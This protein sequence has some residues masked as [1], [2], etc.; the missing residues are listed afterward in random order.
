MAEKGPQNRRELEGA[1]V[2]K[3]WSDD[4]YRGY[5]R[6]DPKAAL[7]TE[8]QEIYPDVKLPEGMEVVLLEESP[9][10]VYVVI[11][12]PPEQLEIARFSDRNLIDMS[13]NGQAFVNLN[14]NVNLNVNVNVNVNV[15]AAVNVGTAADQ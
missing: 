11:P 6:K 14:L 10:K 13:E 7:E 5:F 3:F 15:N 8:L 9:E 1:I 2:R 12:T 4:N